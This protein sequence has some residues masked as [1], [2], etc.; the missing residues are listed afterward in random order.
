[1]GRAGLQSKDYP[2]DSIEMR[3]A[4]LAR[5]FAHIET[6]TSEN[7]LNDFPT[8]IHLPLSSLFQVS[9]G[10]KR[11]HAPENYLI[12]KEFD[13]S[14]WQDNMPISP[15]PHTHTHTHTHFS[16]TFLPLLPTSNPVEWLLRQ[17]TEKNLHIQLH[18][19]KVRK[20]YKKMFSFVS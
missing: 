2:R 1:M 19:H 11:T 12:V 20:Q 10:K 3:S 8:L 7:S 14:G 18:A 4:F 16:S 5:S 15:P 13:A 17:S 9:S 6:A